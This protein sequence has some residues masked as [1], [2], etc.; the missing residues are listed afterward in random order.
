MSLFK[1]ISVWNDNHLAEQLDLLVT[2]ELENIR[3][4]FIASAENIGILDFGN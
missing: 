3:F 4:H 1:K 2:F